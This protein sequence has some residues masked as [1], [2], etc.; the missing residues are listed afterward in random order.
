M[1]VNSYATQSAKDATV[2]RKWYVV[3]AEGMTVGRLA[4]QVA[5]ILRGKHKPSYTP[6]VDCG[7]Y[8]IVINAEK[9]RFSGKKET[10]KL[11]FRYTGYPSG[12]RF[13]SPKEVRNR[14]PFFIM[15]NAIKGMLP[16]NA[17]GRQ[18]YRKLKVVVG[19]VHEHEAQQPE[20]LTF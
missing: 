18:M 4:S 6:H 19:P 15:E 7:D 14:K 1:N 5:A 10:D 8:V 2:E 13:R 17:L 16:H 12:D 20:V 9:V 3:D 11:Y